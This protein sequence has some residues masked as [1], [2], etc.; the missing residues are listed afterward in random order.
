MIWYIYVFNMG[1]SWWPRW[2]R[3]CLLCRRLGYDPWLRKIPWTREW[4]STP[5]FFPGEFYGQR[6]L[7]GYSPWDLKESDTSEQLTLHFHFLFHVF[8]SA[9]MISQPLISES[10]KQL[11]ISPEF[12]FLEFSF[13]L[14][15]L[16]L[17]HNISARVK[18]LSSQGGI[19]LLFMTLPLGPKFW[20]IA[21]FQPSFLLPLFFNRSDSG[22]YS[23]LPSLIS[24]NGSHI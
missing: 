3:I 4:Q 20:I 22:L 12:L 16:L 5:V 6:H 21:V 18:L 1:L 24:Q 2:Y 23:N 8:S 7:V 15:L 14:S 9:S 17:F 13:S 19:S 10:P 11:K